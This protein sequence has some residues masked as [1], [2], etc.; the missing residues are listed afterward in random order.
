MKLKKMLALLLVGTMGLVGCSGTKGAQIAGTEA[1]AEETTVSSVEPVKVTLLGAGYGDKSFWDSAKAGAEEAEKLF[2]EQ[3]EMNIIDMTLDRKK[4]LSATYEAAESDA[5]VIITGSFLQQ[6][7]LEEVASQYPDKHWIAFDTQVDYEEYGLENVYSMGYKANESGYL[8]GMVA[9]YMTTSDNEGINSEKSIGF[10]GGMDN[11]PIVHDFL[12]GYIEGAQSVEPD[13]KIA[14]SY[15]GNFA[16]SAKGKEIAL[17]QF[18]SSQADVVFTVAGAAGTGGVEAAYN[19]GKYVIGVDSDQSLLYEGREEQ[20]HI[21]TSALK[22]VDQSIIYALNNYLQDELP[23]GNYE[24]LGIKEESAGIVYN[25][26][27]TSYVDEAFIET[28]KET[29]GKL[30]SG[31]IVVTSS[32]DVTTDEVR[33]LVESVK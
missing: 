18:N 26:I 8:A 31:E 19:Q 28:L 10:M 4:W 14:V 25:D 30:A 5:D 16:D 12:I 27:L 33:A 9:A 22:R 15:V 6:E 17:A 21:L 24:A 1:E 3:V 32:S 7:N 20:K 2:G 29:E 23:L 13:I 11:N